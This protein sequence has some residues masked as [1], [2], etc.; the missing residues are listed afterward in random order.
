MTLR[1]MTYKQLLRLHRQC[2]KRNLRWTE[3]QV[4]RELAVCEGVPRYFS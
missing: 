4:A 2:C 3:W 1:D